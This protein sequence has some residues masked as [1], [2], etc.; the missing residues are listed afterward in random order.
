MKPTQ[1]ATKTP[2]NPPVKLRA[3]ILPEKLPKP[4]K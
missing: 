2:Y 3:E 1:K 4:K